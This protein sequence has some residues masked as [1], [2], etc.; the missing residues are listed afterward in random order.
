MNLRDLQYLVAVAELQ[1]FGKAAEACHTSQ[2]TLSIQIKKLEEYLGVQLLERSNKHV[3][4]TT[5]G[6]A[7]VARAR[8]ILHEAEQIKQ[9]ALSAKDPFTGTLT[10]GAFPTLAPYVFPLFVPVLR[11]NLPT[12]ELM[13]VEEKTEQLLEQLY[14]GNLDAALI[15]LPVEHSQLEA[16][17]LFHEPF[18]LALSADHPLAKLP[19]IPLEKLADQHI[20]LLDEGH[21][22]RDQSLSLCNRIGKGESNRYRATSLETLRNM[23][24][25]G[26]GMTFMPQLAV[27]ESSEAIRYIRFAPPAPGRT[28]ALVYRKSSGRKLLFDRL[29]VLMRE[30]L[31][32]KNML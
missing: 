23:I 24:A 13:L 14:D 17:E 9:I 7:V 30:V 32:R 6:E 21:C 29:M 16:Q 4:L 5:V 20:L 27:Q 12:L 28:I 25:A 19:E 1:H 11:Q 15:A 26:N 3:M 18:W 2:P 22:L 8:A 10:L 31:I